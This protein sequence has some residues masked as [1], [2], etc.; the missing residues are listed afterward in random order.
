MITL[1][2]QAAHNAA[3]AGINNTLVVKTTIES[4]PVVGGFSAV[5]WF[6]NYT[7]KDGKVGYTSQAKAIQIH[8]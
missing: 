7:Q 8:V 2:K 6:A 1:N 3:K 4:M 5:Y